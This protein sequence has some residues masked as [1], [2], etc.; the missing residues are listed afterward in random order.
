MNFETIFF[1]IT[2]AAAIASALLM[3]T[4]RN[5]IM[6]VLFL[7]VN[8]FCLALIYLILRAQFIAIIQILVYAGAIMVLFLFTIMLLNLGDEQQLTEKVSYR[9]LVALALSGALFFEVMMGIALPMGTGPTQLHENAAQIGT[10]ESIGKVLYTEYLF[11]FEATSILLLAAIVGVV[12][13][14]K[15]KME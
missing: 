8:F 13:L 2:A 6:S 1:L 11:P 4:R 15:K 10:V 14:A 9:K 12:L 7:I 3:V 5:P